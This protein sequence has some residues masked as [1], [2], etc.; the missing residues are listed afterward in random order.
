MYDV[1]VPTMSD[2]LTGNCS[3]ENG[4]QN[5]K[6]T[7]TVCTRGV[8]D[9][10]IIRGPTNGFNVKPPTNDNHASVIQFRSFLGY[11]WTKKIRKSPFNTYSSRIS[12]YFTGSRKLF[13]NRV[14]SIATLYRRY[15]KWR[16]REKT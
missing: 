2:L 7:I 6:R 1:R 11:E 10:K 3:D 15:Q 14:V 9:A 5:I 12:F 13:R 16:N 8:F 4:R